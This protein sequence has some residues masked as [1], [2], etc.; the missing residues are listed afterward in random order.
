MNRG[1]VL[2]KEFIDHM[3]DMSSS[4]ADANCIIE[5]KI[6]GVGNEEKNALLSRLSESERQILADIVLETRYSAIYDVLDYL[7]W[8]QCCKE[9][10]I[11]IDGET[12]VSNE[13]EG[14]S[15]DYIGRK[16]DEWDWPE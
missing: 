15:C 12:L 3:V 5:G 4:C 1:L 11:S 13:F 2:Y 16:S 8:L 7:E 6:P 10:T 9:M 14:F